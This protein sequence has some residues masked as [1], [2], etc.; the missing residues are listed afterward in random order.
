LA[1]EPVHH[2]LVVL[3]PRDVVQLDGDRVVIGGLELVDVVLNRVDTIT[4][5]GEVQ[6]DH[7]GPGQHGTRQGH[8]PRPA[9]R[10]KG[11]PSTGQLEKLPPGPFR[12]GPAVVHLVTHRSPSLLRLSSP[13]RLLRLR[14]PRFQP[15]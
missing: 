14:S 3:W 12:L 11:S 9:E 7:F 1:A 6:V 13:L 8:Y 5:H 4:P 10:G 15:A 2:R